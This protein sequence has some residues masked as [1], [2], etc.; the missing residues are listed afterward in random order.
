[1]T[2]H[3]PTSVILPTNRATPVLEEVATQLRPE[4]ELLVVCDTAEDPITRRDGEL[5][6]GVRLVL[7]GEPG[8]CSG[9]A[10]AVAA[11][12]EAAR[13]DRLVWT[14]DD[15]HHPPDWLQR[16]QADYDRHGPVTELPVVVGRD[17]LSTVLEPLYAL[18]GTLGV[19]ATDKVWAGAVIFE[20]DDLVVEEATFLAA[21]R[22][23]ISDDGLLSESLEV[24]PLWRSRQVE[25]GGTIRESLERHVRFVQIVARH[26]PRG[27]VLLTG[28]LTLATVACLLF[29]IGGFA[30]STVL[31]AG[32]YSVLGVRR[33][34][35]LLAY[36]SVLVQIPLFAYASARRTFVWGGRRY[37][38]TGKFDVTVADK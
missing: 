15:F 38:W 25:V 16:L 34:T 1:M 13:H 30:L 36:P 2:D 23:T 35:F 37:R 12:M 5:P 29:P 9:K 22:R 18:A 10:N 32:V 21:L 3:P 26:E 14:D 28:L 11:G 6:D 7:A 20:R 4:D 24:T 27:T 17:A 33:R 8:G 31:A 19:Y